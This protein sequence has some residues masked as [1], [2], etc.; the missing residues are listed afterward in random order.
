MG[1]EIALSNR[2]G[3]V[4]LQCGK[5]IIAPTASLAAFVYFSPIKAF[6]CERQRPCWRATL[7]CSPGPGLDCLSPPSYQTRTLCVC[8]CLCTCL[9]VCFDIRA[10]TW[11]GGILEMREQ[12]GQTSEV[13][14]ALSKFK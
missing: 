7:L 13:P 3:P 11:S 12:V 10:P 2:Q 6:K 14:L 1:L 9:C 4:N 5:P 8:E